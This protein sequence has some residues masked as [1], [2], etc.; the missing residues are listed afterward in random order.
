MNIRSPLEVGLIIR[1][2]RR[3]LGM[4]QAE[5]ARRIG[6]GR[7]WVIAVERGKSRAELGLVLRTLVALDLTLEIKGRE[8][9]PVRQPEIPVVD[10]DAI[11]DAAR[12]KRRP[13][14]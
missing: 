8:T 1:E 14:T 12:G 11:I 9:L 5:L 6:V 7:H 4:N 13:L 2:R 3:K 10:I